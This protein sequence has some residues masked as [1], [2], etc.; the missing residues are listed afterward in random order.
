MEIDLGN[1]DN[2]MQSEKDGARFVPLG[3]RRARR[4]TRRDADFILQR[5]RT[6]GHNIWGTFG[7]W[8]DGEPP[9][10][11]RI[12]CSR[13][14]ARYST[15]DYAGEATLQEVASVREARADFLNRDPDSVVIER[16]LSLEDVQPRQRPDT[17][18][19][20]NLP[21]AR[22][23]VFVQPDEGALVFFQRMER[24]G[25]RRR[26]KDPRD[27]DVEYLLP[28][29]TDRN[30]ECGR[31]DRLHYRIPLYP[32][33]SFDLEGEGEGARLKGTPEPDY[34]IVIKVLVFKRQNS[35]SSQVIQRA[36][37][38]LGLSR[39][40]LLKY[41]PESAVFDEV[42][43]DGITPAART[44]LLLHGTFSSTEGTYGDL[45]E[46]RDNAEDVFLSRLL[47]DGHFEQILAFDHDTIFVPPAENVRRFDETLAEHSLV[48][49]VR[50]VGFSR[51]ALLLKQMAISGETARIEHGVT[52]AGANHVGY[53]SALRGLNW[54]L[55]ALRYMTPGGAAVKMVSAIAQHSS[56]AIDRLEGLRAMDRASSINQHILEHPNLPTTLIPISGQFDISLVDGFFRRMT[57]RA[58][59]AAISLLLTTRSHDWVVASEQQRR[60]APLTLPED[61]DPIHIQSRHT[62]MVGQK[63]P[64]DDLLKALLWG[65]D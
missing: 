3:Q 37:R 61:F 4:V 20:D 60:H 25:G 2:F 11:G 44:L 50:A 48:H 56:S 33:V 52:I 57:R 36:A 6:P 8:E 41:R 51:G 49:P 63:L 27:T 30:N 15:P 43:G 65:R 28:E 16:Y 7:P 21:Q 10:T 40:N 17:F 32:E 64:N 12:L 26:L 59:N 31:R 22:L 47:R 53:F 24:E 14:G 1:R 45:F 5:V 9:F 19:L 34:K 23:T 13:N 62:R 58:L 55:T 42:E 35:T 39:H 38:R 29:A 18:T 54:L 46:K